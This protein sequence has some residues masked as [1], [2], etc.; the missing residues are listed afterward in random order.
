MIGYNE[1][2][3]AYT[4]EYDDVIVCWDEEPDEDCRKQA[5]A[6]RKAYNEH[7]RDIAQVIYD[8]TG[9]FFG[10]SDVDEVIAKLARPQIYPDN[11]QVVYCEHTLDNE[12]IITFEYSADDFS[13]IEY[14]AVDG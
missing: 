14:V 3:G 2:I 11:G 13:D 6:V 10:V 9:E 4:I 8:E 12:H 5:D 1:E 7:V